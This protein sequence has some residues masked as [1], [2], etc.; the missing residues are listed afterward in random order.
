VGDLHDFAIR[1][2][3]GEQAA[4]SVGSTAVGR[5]PF[6]LVP[7]QTHLNRFQSL[8]DRVPPTFLER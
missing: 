1:L 6:A 8:T 7:R 3:A 2:T 5:R 4:D